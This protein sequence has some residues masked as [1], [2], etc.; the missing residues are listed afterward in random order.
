M[1]HVVTFHCVNLNVTIVTFRFTQWRTSLHRHICSPTQKLNPG[2]SN[3]VKQ[4]QTEYLFNFK[5][6]SVFSEPV[7]YT[8]RICSNLQQC[9]NKHDYSLFWVCSYWPVLI[10]SVKR[11][12]GG[13]AIKPSY[14]K[15]E[16]VA[17]CFTFPWWNGTGIIWSRLPSIPQLFSFTSPLLSTSLPSTIPF[18]SILSLT[19][20]AEKQKGPMCS[21][22]CCLSSWLYHSVPTA[23]WEDWIQG[24]FSPVL[25]IQREMRDEYLLTVLS[26]IKKWTFKSSTLVIYFQ[27]LNA[28]I[29][30]WWNSIVEKRKHKKIF[31]QF[32]IYPSK[33]VY[34]WCH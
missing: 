2:S 32:W 9:V 16:S 25:Y 23:R 31:F 10:I 26:V 21:A 17:S 1:Y 4:Q 33:A 15:R 8:F 13:K 14:G 34:F 28:L 24:V 5:L 30:H 27:L 3:L 29:I 20:E 22:I 7:F 12:A 6:F 18:L 11:T 19:E